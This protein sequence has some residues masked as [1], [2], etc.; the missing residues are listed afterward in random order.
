MG[1]TGKEPLKHET[2][3]SLLS[4]TEDKGVRKFASTPIHFMLGQRSNFIFN[5][6]HNAKKINLDLVYR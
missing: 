4:D 2:N 6:L 1:T 3:N 5:K